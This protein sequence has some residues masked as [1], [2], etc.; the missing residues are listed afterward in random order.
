MGQV[1]LSPG[2]VCFEKARTVRGYSLLPL[3]FIPNPIFTSYFIN[4]KKFNIEPEEVASIV[5]LIFAIVGYVSLFNGW[6]LVCLPAFAVAFIAN[7]GKLE[8]SNDDKRLMVIDHELKENWEKKKK[9]RNDK[10]RKKLNRWRPGALTPNCCYYIGDENAAKVR[11][12]E[13][14]SKYLTLQQV[15]DARVAKARERKRNIDK[16]GWNVS[17]TYDGRDD[18]HTYGYCDEF[19]RD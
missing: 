18:Y 14:L 17:N 11:S 8:I 3:I 13:P 2:F 10:K 4:M 6:W 1:L 9:K 5:A 19:W 7:P 16:R 15:H 12:G